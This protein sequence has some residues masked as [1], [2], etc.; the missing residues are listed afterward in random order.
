M[1]HYNRILITGAAGRLGSQLRAG[2]APLAQ[3]IRLADREPLGPLALHADAS[4]SAVNSAYRVRDLWSRF[5]VP[6]A[7]ASRLASLRGPV[8]LVD[9]L[10]DSRWTV[11]VAGRLLRQ[12]GA[13]AVL[14]LALGSVG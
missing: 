4:L 7:M 10:I 8:L 2:L 3:V 6:P 9:D 1:P 12:A 14:P 13:D 5:S 11:T